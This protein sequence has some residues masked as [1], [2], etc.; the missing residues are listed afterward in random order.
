MR[1]F[2]SAALISSLLF[3][4]PTANSDPLDE[5]YWKNFYIIPIGR[6][7]GD[8]INEFRTSMLS[9]TG[10]EEPANIKL[11]YA[12]VTNFFLEHTQ[13]PYYD[14]IYEP[15]YPFVFAD[16]RGWEITRMMEWAKQ[17][18][19]LVHVAVNGSPWGDNGD[20]SVINLS[21]FL[22]TTDDGFHGPG[23]FNQRDRFGRFRTASQGTNPLLD[24]VRDFAPQL[25]M[26]LSLSPYATTV[27]DYWERNLRQ[28]VRISQ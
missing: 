10:G 15:Y 1:R 8:T 28:A 26:Q 3:T 5:V 4:N 16:D 22:E 17:E 24:E 9:K 11:A 20:Q 21:N 19:A 14:Y 6:W 23:G 12:E 18:D 13:G 7:N 27:S 25:E 2:Y